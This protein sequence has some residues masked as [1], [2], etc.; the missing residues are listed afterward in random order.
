[1]LRP[2]LSMLCIVIPSHVVISESIGRMNMI[3]GI[4]P[5]CSS[6]CRMKCSGVLNGAVGLQ[7]G[8]APAFL[9]FFF[10]FGFLRSRRSIPRYH[11]IRWDIPP[12][13]TIHHDLMDFN[14]FI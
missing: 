11:I 1:V 3:D 7:L 8:P 2:P 12:V 9:F 13:G 4:P 14:I 6:F 10:S 5:F